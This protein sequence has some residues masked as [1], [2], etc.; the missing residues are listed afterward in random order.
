MRTASVC[1]I[2]VLSALSIACSEA[3]P[4]ELGAATA[5]Q[6]PAGAESGEPNLTT[7]E[8][9]T[10]L[11]SWIEAKPDSG[12]ALLFAPWRGASWGERRTIAEGTDW[13]V[14]WADFPSLV[15]LP[16]GDLVAHWL[17]RSGVGTYAYGVRVARSADMGAS[18]S[19]P[20][21]PHT[22]E[23]ATE[24]GFVT[25]LPAGGD[26]VGAVWLDGRNYA[27]GGSEE[28]TLRYA[29]I[30]RDGGLGA[31]R[32]LDARVCDCCQTDMA[33]TT[34]GV[35]A[36]YRDRS[37]GEI[38]DIATVRLESGSWSEPSVVYADNWHI[39]ACPVNGPQI[40][41]RGDNVAVAWFS[42]PG[43][44]ARVQVAFSTDGGRTFGAPVR[45]D[46]GDP[47]GRVDVLMVDDEIAV[48]SWLER[49]GGAAEV[50]ARRVMSSG[51]G[52]SVVVTTTASARASGF[53][54]MARAGDQLVFAW[55]AAGAQSGGTASTAAE[56][57][58]PAQVRTAL[59]PITA[60]E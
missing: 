30:A 57:A 15:S 43:D 41:A 40:A 39:E 18:W 19:A 24:H 37:E 51:R 14:N 26:S 16:N 54:R 22:D 29:A 55:T 28:M 12:V 53:P 36:V 13:F 60:L 9:G 4:G 25:L 59:V 47:A 2:S 35:V 46:D 7:L 10:V 32:V 1:F 3:G 23:T 17:Q 49:T 33:R 20:V 31:E 48:V 44:S 5:M 45:V 58:A 8:D 50:R 21:T 56:G 42:A 52:P 6:S 11:L 34:N 27:E 38:R